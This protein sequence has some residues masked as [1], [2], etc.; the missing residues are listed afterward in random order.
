MKPRG[1][2]PPGGLK[3]MGSI[4]D[5]EMQC[6]FH[7]NRTEKGTGVRGCAELCAE[8]SADFSVHGD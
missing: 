4:S 7:S 5:D 6:V 8:G 3:V 2:E 1:R